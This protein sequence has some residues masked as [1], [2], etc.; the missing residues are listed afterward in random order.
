MIAHLLIVVV[1]AVRVIMKRPAAGVALAWLL[2][3]AA[4]PFVGALFYLLTHAVLVTRPSDHHASSEG[5]YP[6][7]PTAAFKQAWE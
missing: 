5:C 3:I 4:A 2:L 6:R 1:V 7:E